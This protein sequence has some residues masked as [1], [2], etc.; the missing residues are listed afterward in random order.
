VAQA[1]QG[2]ARSCARRPKRWAAKNAKDSC[3]CGQ[4]MKFGALRSKIRLNLNK[5]FFFQL[6][7][8]TLAVLNQNKD[9]CSSKERKTRTGNV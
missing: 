9:R 1:V 6:L 2:K 4:S 3:K 5:E 7:Y 8:Q